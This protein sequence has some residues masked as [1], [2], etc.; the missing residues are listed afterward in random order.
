MKLLEAMKQKSSSEASQ[1]AETWLLWS[2]QP[3]REA[4]THT[5]GKKRKLNGTEVSGA[6]PEDST[7]FRHV[8]MVSGEWAVSRVNYWLAAAFR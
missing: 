7:I 5:M 4:R 1:E 6:G 2:D 8:S 3:S